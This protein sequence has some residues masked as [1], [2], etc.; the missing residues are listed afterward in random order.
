MNYNTYIK[1]TPATKDILH[2]V[3]G[4]MSDGIWEN[5]RA[6]EKYWHSLGVEVDKDGYIVIIDRD[7][8]CENA[9]EFFANKIKQII[10]I[11]I[12]DGN[13]K[14]EWSRTCPAVSV[15][16]DYGRN[17]AT[18]GECYR[19]YELLKGRGISNKIYATQKNYEVSVGDVKLNIMATSKYEAE[20]AA[21]E[22]IKKMLKIQEI[23]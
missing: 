8:V 6:M 16:L 21:L 18:V 4:Q 7:N 9:P 13:H 3:I 12:D 11:E 15:Y 17:Y 2:A 19:L 14:L 23:G 22:Q 5:S 20:K 10:K 1:A